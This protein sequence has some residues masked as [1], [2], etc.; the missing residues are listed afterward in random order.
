MRRK[1]SPSTESKNTSC[2]TRTEMVN[3]LYCF[4]VVF[5]LFNYL[6]C[7]PLLMKSSSSSLCS[8]LGPSCRRVEWPVFRGWQEQI[9]CRCEVGLSSVAGQDDVSNP[10][11]V[12]DRMLDRLG[13]VGR[14][15][16]ES[17][18]SSSSSY[19]ICN[20]PYVAQK[21]YS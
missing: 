17:S 10:G 13:N 11:Q 18:S 2:V 16:L 6:N 8:Q 1:I 19:K 9:Q 7:F 14:C 5:Y 3:D 12:N 4:V 20:V 15:V 21:C